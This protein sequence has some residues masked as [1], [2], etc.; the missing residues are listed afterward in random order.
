MF[1]LGKK[2]IDLLIRGILQ[3]QSLWFQWLSDQMRRR[4][5]IYTK[6]APAFIDQLLTSQCNRRLS[7]ACLCHLLCHSNT[8]ITAPN[9]HGYS[10]IINHRCSPPSPMS[11]HLLHLSKNQTLFIAVSF[12]WRLIKTCGFCF[13]H[14]DAKRPCRCLC[15]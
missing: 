9:L 7:W 1:A 13:Y 10:W 15:K 8:E 5:L 14:S 3:K 12:I 2:S 4:A 6:Q 11:P